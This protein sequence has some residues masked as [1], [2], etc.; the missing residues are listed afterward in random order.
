M[1]SDTMHPPA[2]PARSKWVKHSVATSIA[3][4]ISIA[5]DTMHFAEHSL[6]P[7]L[8]LFI[9]LWLA[10]TFFA[11]GLVKATSWQTALLLAT[12]E[13]PVSWL[14]PHTSAAVGLAV[15]LI[16]PPLI[17]IG[18]FTRIAAIPLL[19]LTLVIQ[20]AYK[21]LSENLFGRCCSA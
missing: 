17:A 14:D 15:E 18:L 13:Y 20:F 9:R 21:P 1:A 19:I 7:L 11:S 5:V 12:Y 6:G 8:D 2:A 4:V 16:C 3:R 10:Q